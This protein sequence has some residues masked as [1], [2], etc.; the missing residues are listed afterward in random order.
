MS[1]LNIEEISFQIIAAVGTARSL[2]IEAIQEAKEGNFDAAQE[3]IKEGHKTF[4]GGHDAHFSLI[5]QEAD[6]DQPAVPFNIILMHAEDQL[7]SAEAFGILADN[8][9]DVYKKLH[10]EK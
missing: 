6:P 7:M 5:T 1:N 3:K 8:F 10:K 9:I 4:K 2:F